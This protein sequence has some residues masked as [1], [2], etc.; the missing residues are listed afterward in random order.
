[1]V[2]ERFTVIYT[3]LASIPKFHLTAGAKEARSKRCSLQGQLFWL[4]RQVAN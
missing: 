2:D 4:A 3:E 1:M